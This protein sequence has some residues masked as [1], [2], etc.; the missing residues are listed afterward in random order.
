VWA[1]LD[2]PE[3]LQFTLFDPTANDW[4]DVPDLT[5]VDYALT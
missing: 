1:I 4:A 2:L 3:G 5:G